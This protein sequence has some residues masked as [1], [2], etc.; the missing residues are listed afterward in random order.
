MDKEG[1]YTKETG[2]L[3]ECQWIGLVRFIRFG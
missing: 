1:F 2:M 3:T